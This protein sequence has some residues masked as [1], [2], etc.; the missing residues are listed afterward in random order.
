MRLTSVPPPVKAYPPTPGPTLSSLCN[1]WMTTKEEALPGICQWFIHPEKNM[2]RVS[3]SFTH[4]QLANSSR[5]SPISYSDKVGVIDMAPPVH[6]TTSIGLI[7]I[8]ASVFFILL[9]TAFITC[10][11]RRKRVQQQS[12]EEMRSQRVSDHIQR[13]RGQKKDPPPNYVAVLKMKK[14]EEDDLPSYN[15]ALSL[16]GGMCNV[17]DNADN[18]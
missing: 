13:I 2:Q 3:I 10:I 11:I 9:V 17:A 5:F 12:D 1:W 16:E 4:N 8:L 6:S 18:I 14:E 15:E 7:L